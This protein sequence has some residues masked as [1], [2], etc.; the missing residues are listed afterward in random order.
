[1]I[2]AYEPATQLIELLQ[3]LC[4]HEF[5]IIVVDDGG[6]TPF[7]DIFKEA[8]QYAAVLTH[9]K[10]RGKGRAI[11]TGL[12]Y[13]KARFRAPYTVVIMDADGQHSV[14]DAVRV[15]EAAEQKK[16]TLVLGSR[17]LKENVPLRSR[18]GNTVTRA[19]YK[20]STGV[21]VHD[22]QTGLRGFGDELMIMLMDIDGE[23]YEYEMNVLLEFAHDRIPIEEIEISTIYIDNNSSSH[24]NTLTDS[25]RIYKEI[26]KYSAS[27]FISFLID[28]SL[29]CVLCVL[30]AGLGSISLTVSN[31]LSRAVSAYV[32]YTINR[33]VVFKS[34]NRVLKSAIQYFALAATILI[35]NTVI[36]NLLAGYFGVNRF[37]AKIVTEILFFILSWLVQRF[38][39]F[40]KRA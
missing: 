34:R 9:E 30:T 20:T 26:L 16:G 31:I 15:C 13:I 19:V 7:S 1:M 2:P 22:T 38:F 33:K 11:K 36:L 18:F 8:A 10:N 29:Y 28:Y 39:I 14:I 3:S 17:E 4:D 32:N 37:T 5:S 27:S 12:Q 35:G 40:N 25:Y 21:C 6:G 24:F 23:R